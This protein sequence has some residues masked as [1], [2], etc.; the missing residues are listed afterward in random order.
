[1]SHEFWRWSATQLT[2]A[3]RIRE[4]SVQEVVQAH[5]D[6]IDAVNG[7]VNAITLTLAEQA[8]DAAKAADNT[9]RDLPALHGL[10]ITV[11]ENIDVLGTPT[12]NGL[13]SRKDLYPT[14]DAPII[15]HLKQAGAII[16][17]RTNMPDFGMRWHTDNDLHGPT[18]NPWNGKRTPGGSSGG[19]AAAIATGMSPLGIGNDMGGS[20]RQPAVNCGIAGLRPTTGRVSWVTSTIYDYSPTYYDQIAAVNGPMARSVRDLRLALGILS[21]SDPSD[22]LWVPASTPPAPQNGANRVGLVRDPSGEGIAPGVAKALTDAAN[23]LTQAGYMVEDIEAPLMEEA[24]RTIQQFYETET[25][26][27]A[28][29][30]ALFSQD[31][32]TVLLSALGDGKPNAVTYRNAIAERHRIAVEW[33]VLMDRYPLILGPVSTLEPFEVGYDISSPNAMQCL[34]RSFRLTELCNLLGLPSVALPA[35][36]MNGLPQGVQII[37]RRF[38]EDRCF[39]AAQAIEEGLA[40]PIPIDPIS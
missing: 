38:D 28:D 1:M 14:K 16:V 4:I 9:A 20:T 23:L 37:G 19:E 30:L 27:L 18:L 32:K 13:V 2:T 36:L 25:T 40:L 29:M 34:I 17:G 3:L 7:K 24:D 10:P 35:A 21:Q 6:R 8:L 33:S 12:T 5:L 15:R 31:A 11:K 26:G 22:P 39:T